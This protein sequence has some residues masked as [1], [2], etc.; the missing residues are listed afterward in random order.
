MI[1]F[2]SH[3]PQTNYPINAP[4]VRLP[5]RPR[6]PNDVVKQA[7]R[8]L[9]YNILSQI[10][11]SGTFL[12]AI[13]SSSTYPWVSGSVSEW[14]IKSFRFGDSYR[15]SELFELVAWWGDPCKLEF[16]MWISYRSESSILFLLSSN[17]IFCVFLKKIA[18]YFEHIW[19]RL[20]M[21][22]STLIQQDY[23]PF[24][25]VCWYCKAIFPE[26]NFLFALFFPLLVWSIGRQIESFNI[27][28][29]NSLLDI[30]PNISLNISHYL[31]QYFSSQPFLSSPLS[32]GLGSKL[33]LSILRLK[34]ISEFYFLLKSRSFE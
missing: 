11:M 26:K 14:V 3:F 22:T 32:D 10:S 4:W 33:S 21:S 24:T 5:D 29:N 9:V 18:F 28:L 12:D 23:F 31:F 34:N 19:F 6:A 17:H 13:A 30:S 7:R 2:I 8:L 16:T 15:I 1:F 27:T 25:N 20:K